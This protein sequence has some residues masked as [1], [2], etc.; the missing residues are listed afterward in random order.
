MCHEASMTFTR[1]FVYTFKSGSVYESLYLDFAN[2]CGYTYESSILEENM[3][4]IKNFGEYNKFELLGVNC[5]SRKRKRMS[6]VCK[7]VT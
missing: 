2:M 6:V 1:E 7:R 4:L 5:W 3:R